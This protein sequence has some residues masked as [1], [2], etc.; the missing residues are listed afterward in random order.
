R[1]IGHQHGHYGLALLDEDVQRDGAPS[2]CTLDRGSVT[3]ERRATIMDTWIDASEL[4]HDGNHN[5]LADQFFG[6]SSWAA[7]DNAW[8]GSSGVFPWRLRTPMTRGAVNPGPTSLSCFSRMTPRIVPVPDA[9]CGPVRL[10]AHTSSGEPVRGVSVDLLHGGRSIYQGE[11][12]ATGEVALY[13][14]AP[15][16]HAALRPTAG[17][18]GCLWINDPVTVGTSCGRVDVTSD[19]QCFFVP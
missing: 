7:V 12:D 4:C 2:T 18:P 14:A 3:E 5:P 19:L 1:A 10:V 8:S 13:G 15:G 11:T 17:Q 16:D 6:W 9:A